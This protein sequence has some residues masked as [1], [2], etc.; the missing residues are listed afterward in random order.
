MVLPE[1]LQ[2][3][4][5]TFHINHWPLSSSTYKL[6]P[7]S[8]PKHCI[9]FRQQR[10]KARQ[11]LPRY[12]RKCV[13]P[14]DRLLVGYETAQLR[15]DNLTLSS[16]AELKRLTHESSIFHQTVLLMSHAEIMFYR[17]L[18]MV[19]MLCCTFCIPSCFRGKNQVA[20]PAG[21]QV[22]QQDPTSQSTN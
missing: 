16:T 7:E 11:I 22:L 13:G 21:K 9:P 3:A 17:K 8:P 6:E 1:A 5:A 12:K 18:T 2:S 19:L 20:F 10:A 15:V 4:G 14:P